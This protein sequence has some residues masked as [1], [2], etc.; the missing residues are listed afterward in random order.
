MGN[1]KVRY[2]DPAWQAIVLEY[3]DKIIDQGFAGAYLDIIDAFEYWSDPDNGEDTVL[4]EAE[5]AR[6][7]IEFIQEIASHARARVPEFLIFPQNGERILDY[8][9]SGALLATI[10]GFGIE[11]LFYTGLRRNPPELIAERTAYLDRVTAVGKVILSVD[12]V[13]DGQGY[14]GENRARIDDYLE[15]AKAKG[16]LAYAARA[17]RELDVINIIPGVQP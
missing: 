16:Y 9:A 17:D 4:S 3:L 13:D 8:D 2:W 10:S 6:R 1:Y 5:A 12:Y 11:D 15:R 14:R 7:M